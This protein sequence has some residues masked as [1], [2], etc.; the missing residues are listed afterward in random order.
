MN[1]LFD[2]APRSSVDPRE[3]EK[4]GRLAAEWWNPDGSLRPL[5]KL[6]PVRL[7]YIRDHAATH[8]GR[9][10]RQPKPL[11]G[12]RVLDVGCG[13]GLLCEPMARLGAEVTGIDPAPENIE[14]ARLH[15]GQSGLSLDYRA[16]AVETLPSA[17]ERFDIVLAMEVIEHVAD[18]D[19]FLR[20][21][22]ELL[23][24]GGLLFAA[25]ISRTRKAYALAIVAAERI[26]RWLPPGTHDY[27]KLVRPEELETS[28]RAAGLVV[29]HRSGVSYDVLSDTWRPSDDLDVNYMLVADKPALPK[30]A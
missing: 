29:L 30:S 14:V 17:S 7:A 15:A 13:G 12:L 18:R 4:F 19:G 20:A 5:H 1:S 16:V 27:E 28:L 24:P 3:V 9:S 22:A 2:Q 21:C 10:V 11:S 6:N 26:L 8:F 25:T 23:L